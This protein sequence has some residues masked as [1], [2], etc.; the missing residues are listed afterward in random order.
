MI[1]EDVDNE[2]GASRR[3]FENQE[4]DIWITTEMMLMI[5]S[6][7]LHVLQNRVSNNWHFFDKT[8]ER[9]HAEEEYFV[10]EFNVERIKCNTT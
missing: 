9:R 2:R 4:T 10:L 8:R 1:V 6:Y 3:W 7:D 5:R